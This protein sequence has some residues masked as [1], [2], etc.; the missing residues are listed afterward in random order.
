MD[1]N[2]EQKA[3]LN[4]YGLFG[5]SIILSL[6][7]FAAAAVLSLL[8]FTALLFMAYGLR[9]RAAPESLQDNHA[10]YV[11]RT[12]WITALFSAITSTLASVYMLGR[13][14]YAPFDPCVESILSSGETAVNSGN[15]AVVYEAAAPCVDGFLAFN[16][17]V[18]INA[19]LIAALPLMLY[20]GYRFTKGLGRALKGYR[21]ANPKSWF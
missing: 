7:P 10:T 5:A 6:V 20:L 12:F 14:D 16:H 19:A 1:D 21:L 9:K 13:I 15:S 18:W 11:I 3:I 8:F 17:T 2:K 4:L